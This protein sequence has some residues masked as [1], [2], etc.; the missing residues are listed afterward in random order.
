MAVV[1]LLALLVAGVGGGGV[2]AEGEV[3]VEVGFHLV[4]EFLAGDVAEGA[5]LELAEHWVS[6]LAVRK[7]K[8]VS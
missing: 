3:L 1:V 4:G 8:R 6:R 2:R 5:A 7:H